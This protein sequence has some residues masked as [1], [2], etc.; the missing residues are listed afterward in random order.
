MLMVGNG[1]WVV[2]PY[3]VSQEMPGSRLIQPGVKEEWDRRPRWLDDYSYY[4]INS[5]SLP[6]TDMPIMHYGQD[7]DCFIRELVIE[8]PALVPVYVLK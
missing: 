8:Y 1:Q 7:L 4:N 6:I 5:D 2:L 3:L